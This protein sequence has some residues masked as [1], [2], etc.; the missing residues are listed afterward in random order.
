MNRRILIQV[1]APAAVI[2]L[3]LFAGCLLSAWLV[4]QLQS[5]RAILLSRIVT[6]LEACQE[7]EIHLRRLRFLCFVYLLDPDQ[8]L[9]EEI[10]Q[11]NVMFRDSL[12]RAEQSAYWP[13]EEVYLQQIDA[14]YT[15]YQQEFER[16]RAEVGRSGPRRNYRELAYAN[17]IRHVIEPC[18]RLLRFNKDMM[19]ETSQASDHT[20]QV[21]WLVLAALGLVGPASGLLVG[22][23]MARGLS[24][25]IY[26][27]SVRVHDVARKLDQDV[28]SVSVAA[29]GDLDAL[30][31]QLQQ[32][33]PRVEAVAQRLQQEQ[34]KVLHAQQLTAVGQLATSVA[35]E[36]RNP[37]TAIQMLVE[38]ALRSQNRKP[39]NL[40]D[41]RVIH[42]EVERLEQTVQH[43]LDF[44]RL[45][46]PQRSPCDLRD[47]V[48]RAVELIQ[49]RARQQHVEI[50][51]E[52][53]AEPCIADVDRNQ[54]HTVLV[55]LCINALDAMPR[56][57]RLEVRLQTS[58]HRFRLTVADTGTGIPD[59]MLEQLFTP[60]ASSKPTGT[61]LGL[62]MSQRI[63]EE[64]GGSI[65]AGNRAGGGACLTITLPGVERHAHLA[66]SR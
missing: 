64:H 22:F 23:G 30:D 45:P 54:L 13:E 10:Q 18:D 2:G 8:T 61:G 42:R 53:P 34:R 60:F 41:L 58:A 3:L 56:G 44:A 65:S 46:T 28:G 50:V 21:L 19:Q 36:V 49:P 51:Q 1:T 31:R 32:V 52:L 20:N 38:S 11:V 37:L 39:L 29:E 59:A 14:G 7:M 62:C 35:H 66:G 48:G 57:G 12:Q 4:G 43:F 27:L 40:D 17:P 55:N 15:R 5:N 6:S 47:A 16:L 25:S 63:V 9:L 26:Q 24:R 33:I